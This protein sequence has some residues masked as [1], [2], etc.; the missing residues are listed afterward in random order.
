MNIVAG[1][2]S[3]LDG[4][5]LK[6]STGKGIHVVPLFPKIMKPRVLLFLL[7]SEQLLRFSEG[8]CFH[9]TK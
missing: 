2:L 4:K 5:M 3:Y 8:R 6:M 9:Q 1:N 7:L